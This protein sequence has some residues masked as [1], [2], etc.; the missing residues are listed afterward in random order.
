MNDLQVQQNKAEK[1]ILDKPKC[2]SSTEVLEEL[3]WKHLGHR[4]HLHR[5]VFIFRCLHAFNFD[6]KQ[7]NTVF[8]HN[9]RQPK[10]LH[11][12][13]TPKTNWAKRKIAY[14]A[15]FDFNF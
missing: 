5:C 3:E 8:H 7:N 1:L 13:R 11:L 6:F 4:Q 9:T 10:N 15:A 12:P 14:Q 2:S